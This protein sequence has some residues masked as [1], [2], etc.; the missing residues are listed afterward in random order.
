[1][2]T[3]HKGPKVHKCNTCGKSFTQA[4][5][6]RRHIKTIHEGHKDFKCDL[7]KII[8]SSWLSEKTHQNHS[9][10][11]QKFQMWFLWKI[12]YWS[13]FSEKTHQNHSLRHKDF[14]CDT[15][16]KSFNTASY[17][18]KHINNVHWNF[19]LQNIMIEVNW[20]YKL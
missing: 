12:I 7:W 14:K 5:H 8:Y 11:S 19:I 2:K 18:N 13:W 1:M 15:C 20:Y 9:R 10:R 16:G 3:V 6:L 4:G 17:L